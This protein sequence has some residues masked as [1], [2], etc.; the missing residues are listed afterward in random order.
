MVHRVLCWWL[1][2]LR[3]HFE[4]V[5]GAV[6]GILI[7]VGVVVISMKQF[8]CDPSSLTDATALTDALTLLLRPPGCTFLMIY[9]R[10]ATTQQHK[11]LQAGQVM[12]A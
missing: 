9:R 4:N 12:P 10:S 3:C 7:L 1:V 6:G 8:G 11:Q 2:P 5:A